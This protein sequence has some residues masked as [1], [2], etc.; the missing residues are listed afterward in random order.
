[1]DQKLGKAAQ[2]GG[3]I[4]N[5]YAILTLDPLLLETINQN[6]FS[7]TPLHG[8]VLADQASFTVELL[9]LKP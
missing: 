4:D 2:A 9:N 7:Q 6:P 1:M 5:M 3:D 8:V